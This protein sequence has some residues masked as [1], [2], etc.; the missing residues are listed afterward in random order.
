LRNLFGREVGLSPKHFARIGRVRRVLSLAG[1]RR[2]ATVAEDAGFFDQAH[3]ISDFR[4]FMGVSPEAYLAGRLPAVTPCLRLTRTL[5]GVV[6]GP[7]QAFGFTPRWSWPDVF[8]ARSSASHPA[9]GR[10]S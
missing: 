9:R 1:Q 3:M 4:A 8:S 2:W 5:S 7:A 6:A 10:S